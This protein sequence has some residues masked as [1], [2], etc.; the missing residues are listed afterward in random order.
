MLAHAFVNDVPMPAAISTTM[1]GNSHVSI[2]DK[3]RVMNSL[4]EHTHKCQLGSKCV[5]LG[6]YMPSSS[7]HFRRGGP[8]LEFC[9]IQRAEILH[10]HSFRYLLT[11]HRV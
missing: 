9:S 7:S 5:V 2:Y 6:A 11:V 4:Y 3:L 1:V 8:F 10:A